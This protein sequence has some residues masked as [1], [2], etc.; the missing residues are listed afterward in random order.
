[1]ITLVP[2]VLTMLGALGDAKPPHKF[3]QQKAR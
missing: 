3:I 1:M 2:M